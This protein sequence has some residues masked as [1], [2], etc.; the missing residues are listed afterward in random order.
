MNPIYQKC[1]KILLD[2]YDFFT[3][4]LRKNKESRKQNVITEAGGMCRDYRL[5]EDP[6]ISVIRANAVGDDAVDSPIASD[7][8]PPETKPQS[9]QL[10]TQTKDTVQEAI[11]PLVTEDKKE[12]PQIVTSTAQ[13]CMSAVPSTNSDI[14]SVLDSNASAS[15][16]DPSNEITPPLTS[17]LP[18]ASSSTDSIESQVTHALTSI[19]DGIV[20]SC[21]ENLSKDSAID[22]STGETNLSNLPKND[23]LISNEKEEL[24]SGDSLILKDFETSST[25]TMNDNKTNSDHT[26]KNTDL[27]ECVDCSPEPSNNDHEKTTKVANS[28]QMLENS[29][30]VN[31]MQKCDISQ[32]NNVEPEQT[33]E[34]QSNQDMGNA[35][36]QMENVVASNT[37]SQHRADRDFTKYL[38]VEL[39]TKVKENGGVKE[40]EN[41]IETDG[42]GVVGAEPKEHTKSNASTK[43]RL[44]PDIEYLVQYDGTIYNA[45]YQD[46]SHEDPR[47]L[48]D[49]I[50]S[51]DD[52]AINRLGAESP[53]TVQDGSQSESSVPDLHYDSQ[54]PDLLTDHPIGRSRFESQSPDPAYDIH[55]PVKVNVQLQPT[56]LTMSG[57]V[58]DNAVL[59][60][61]NCSEK[62]GWSGWHT[63]EA[64]DDTNGKLVSQLLSGEGIN[65]KITKSNE[66]SSASDIPTFLNSER[67][68][69]MSPGVCSDEDALLQELCPDGVDL[70]SAECQDINSSGLYDI[71]GVDSLTDMVISQISDIELNVSQGGGEGVAESGHS[72]EELKEYFGG[73]VLQELSEG[74]S[75]AYQLDDPAVI[76]ATGGLSDAYQLD[77][78]AVIEATGGLSDAYQLDDP[79]VI[80]AKISQ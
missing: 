77:D 51:Y 60:I 1:S 8:A 35:S 11:T 12:E 44:S 76:E 74:L 64:E 61:N 80:E 78:P 63:V 26:E 45:E 30:L 34:S 41:I 25:K 48:I 32:D 72:Q 3:C 71:L 6:T 9:D 7:S 75:G 27:D 36:I 67:A 15:N 28:D 54:S 18:L 66:E 37:S 20:T 53:Y 50:M 79:A 69:T 38:S 19:I 65:F 59:N 2:N 22:R 55:V 21:E 14:N 40:A 70:T 33:S 10:I 31:R 56:S 29:L 5:K 47:K 46:E 73:N 49:L 16:S 62:S 17:E 57:A 52:D 58:E 68:D 23:V 43:D 42:I 4:I 24:K 13:D 39:D